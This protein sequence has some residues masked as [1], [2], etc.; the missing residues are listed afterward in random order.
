MTEAD[1]DKLVSQA[2]S[3]DPAAQ[4]VL[5][6]ALSTVDDPDILLR[7]AERHY[8]SD[9]ALLVLLRAV[10]LVPTN[11]DALA[12]LAE[13]Y[14]I[15]DDCR[16]A[17]ELAEHALRLNGL[18]VLARYVLLVCEE[19]TSSK[20]TIAD[21]ILAIE[22]TYY[23]AIRAKAEALVALGRKGDGM[24]LLLHYIEAREHDRDSTSQEIAAA[25]ATLRHLANE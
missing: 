18:N 14:A 19:D 20:L 22:P 11:A 13:S 10:Q 17:R 9:G 3:D 5:R 25:K 6:D 8:G 15:Q 2:D 12:S 23:S 21:E 16:S 7:L 24:S 1:L 4:S